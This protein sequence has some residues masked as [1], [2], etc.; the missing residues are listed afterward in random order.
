MDA[1]LDL[2]KLLK[3]FKKTADKGAAVYAIDADGRVDLDQA[4]PGPLR[5]CYATEE[6][7]I[8][9][10]AENA[11][12]PQEFIRQALI[13]DSGSVMSGDFGE[14]LAFFLQLSM[15]LP[16]EFKGPRQ[17]RWKEDRKK[18]LLGSDIVL[19][20][21]P[22]WVKASPDDEV[23]C[24]EVKAKATVSKTYR[25]LQRAHEGVARDKKSR[26]ADTLIWLRA[27]SIKDGPDG[28]S[29]QQIDRFI[30]SPKHGPYKKKFRAVAVID[31]LF[32]VDELDA[33][34]T[35]PAVP[36]EVIVVTIPAL[37]D[38]YTKAF[39]AAAAFEPANGAE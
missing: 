13:P 5:R 30:K 2:Q 21:M 26:L 10:A 33:G 7:I 15:E 6:T 34:W 35:A 14:I 25:P 36:P 16:R 19:L 27:R 37:K 1:E 32:K 31:S 18:A 23:V 3:L 24:A 28:I 11:L 29:S 17:W 20:F 38:C 4:I 12:T 39:D 9:K 22:D 8:A